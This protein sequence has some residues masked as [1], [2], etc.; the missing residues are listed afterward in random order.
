MKI[1]TLFVFSILE[2]TDTTM[3]IVLP[4]RIV[5]ETVVRWINSDP[6]LCF[7]AHYTDLQRALPSGA[8]PMVATLPFLGLF[9]W[10]FFAPLCVK[11]SEDLAIYSELH[12]ALIE[13][14]MQ[15][16]KVYS[17]ENPRISRPYTLSVHSVLLPQ[18][19][20]LIEETMK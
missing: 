7:T 18:L 1:V 16:W 12:C 10:C 9:R 8:I 2:T 4:P 20:A 11:N 14:V 19:K 15:G 3:S 17:E 13:S 5:L 6:C